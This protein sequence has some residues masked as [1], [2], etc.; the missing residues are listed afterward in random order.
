MNASQF[1]VVAVALLLLALVCLL[2]A[3]LLRRRSGLPDGEVVYDDTSGDES[4]ELYSATYGLCGK[5]DYLVEAEDG[6]GIVPVEVK[7]SPAPRNRKPYTSHLMQLAV[8]FLLVEDVLEEDVP[9]GLIRYRDR[10]LRVE[11]SDE[12]RAELLVVLAEMREILQGGEAQ[13]SHNLVRRCVGC[14]VAYA[15][16]ERLD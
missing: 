14:S 13:R 15:C 12:L 3:K 7:S 11:N 9:Y 6:D 10:T 16:D 8:Y 1:M 4:E 2:L 5:P